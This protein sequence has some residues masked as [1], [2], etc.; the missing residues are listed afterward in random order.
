MTRRRS[1]WSAWSQI[2]STGRERSRCCP[3]LEET[4]AQGTVEYALTVFA[5]L[6]VVVTIGALWRAGERGAFTDLVA[7]AAS[8]GLAGL[9]PLDIAL[10]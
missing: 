2:G 4:V 6:A 5:L 3:F 9:G 1:G 10:F 7:K 8:H